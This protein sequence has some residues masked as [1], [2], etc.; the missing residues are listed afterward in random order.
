MSKKG[1]VLT[2]DIMC[3][4]AL[5]RTKLAFGRYDTQHV[6]EVGLM[7]DLLVISSQ[8]HSSHYHS[9][10]EYINITI[11]HASRSEMNAYIK[12]V[13]DSIDSLEQKIETAKRMLISAESTLEK[14]KS[15][16]RDLN[17]ARFLNLTRVKLD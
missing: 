8:W 7:D 13:N 16:L 11:D 10:V 4:K 3:A 2:M 6:S 15:I 14:K 5:K 12:Q 9:D 1:C 17:D